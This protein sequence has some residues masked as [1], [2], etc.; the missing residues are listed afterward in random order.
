MFMF[1]MFL[2]LNEGMRKIYGKGINLY[3]SNMAI[4]FNYGD[5]HFKLEPNVE[6]TAK[7]L[8][9][10]YERPGLLPAPFKF[11]ELAECMS[12]NFF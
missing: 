7:V 11:M 1:F 3:F 2:V 9:W 6:K 8:N 5:R 12:S 10:I 4:Y